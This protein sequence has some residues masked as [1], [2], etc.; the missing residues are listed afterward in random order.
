MPIRAELRSLYPEDWRELSRRVRFE[1]AAGRCQTCGRPHLTR[2]RVLP[3]GRWFDQVAG[4]WRG[5]RGRPTRWPDLIDTVGLRATRVV[6]AAAHV[7]HDPSNNRRRNLRALCQRCH[8]LH[9]RPYHR[10]QRWMSYR[11]RWAIGDLFLGPYRPP[12]A[13]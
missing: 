7:D 13:R 4:T 2:L 3:D 11:R 12:L 9:D 8:L 10:R 5:E 1:R 6:L